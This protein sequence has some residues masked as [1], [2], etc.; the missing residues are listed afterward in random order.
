MSSVKKI[1]HKH[2]SVVDKLPRTDELDYG[3]IAVNYA[4][5]KEFISLKNADNKIVKIAPS[6]EPLFRYDNDTKNGIVPTS[7]NNGCQA[8]G[9]YSFAV[10]Y[11][12]V[13]SGNYSH[14][15]GYNTRASGNYSHAE[16]VNTV[17]SENYS[18][19]EGT[20]TTAS[21]SSCHAEG[22]STTASGEKS[23]AEGYNTIAS[24]GVSHAEGYKTI[25][26]GY[27]S[28][29]EGFYTKTFNY[30]EHASGQYNLSK[31]STEYT[32]ANGSLF[33]I[34][35]GKDESSRH[36]AFEVNKSGEIFIQKDKVNTS[37]MISLQDKLNEI[38]EK[39]KTIETDLSGIN[40]LLNKIIGES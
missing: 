15:E 3:E 25:A 4:S 33:T 6:S 5:G 19:A 26:S 37:E 40:E 30:S 32:D 22:S 21:D 16:G 2:S 11:R 9:E 12:T 34:G 38:S 10:G 1:I 28:H 8:K 29:T 24:G 17:A 31:K 20:N 7:L 27:F 18:H 36:N 14:T 39:Q 35:N 13:A 23:H